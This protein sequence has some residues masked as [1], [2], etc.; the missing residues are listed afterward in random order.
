MCQL[1]QCLAA[2]QW[3]SQAWKPGL[4]IPSP[5]LLQYF[6]YPTV[7]LKSLFLTALFIHGISALLVIR[8]VAGGGAGGVMGGAPRDSG[9]RQVPF[10]SPHHTPGS[11]GLNFVVHSPFPATLL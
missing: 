3:K 1:A 7:T 6:P 2:D 4:L 10:P 8:K 5:E 9:C 11:R